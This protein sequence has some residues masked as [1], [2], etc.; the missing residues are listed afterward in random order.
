M[1]GLLFYANGP[2]FFYVYIILYY[3]RWTDCYPN[4]DIFWSVLPKSI[5]SWS[6]VL[7]FDILILITKIPSLFSG[8]VL[9]IQ[10]F[11]VYIKYILYLYA[12]DD[13]FWTA[14]HPKTRFHLISLFMTLWRCEFFILQLLRTARTLMLTWSCNTNTN[15]KTVLPMRVENHAV[16]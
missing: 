12:N 9:N 2:D 13:M 7:V 4:D 8:V 11:D 10:N 3:N 15:F 1:T 14:L 16:D 6:I 5:F